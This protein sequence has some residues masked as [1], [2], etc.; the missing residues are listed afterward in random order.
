MNNPTEVIRAV[1]KYKHM[2]STEIADLFGISPQAISNKFRR[3]SWDISEVIKV[4][5]YMD[6]KLI[7]EADNIVQFK[8]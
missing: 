2:S 6:C 1:M 8:F 5:E 3:G 7:I 4:L